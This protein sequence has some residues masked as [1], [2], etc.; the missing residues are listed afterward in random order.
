MDNNRKHVRISY[1]KD[2]ELYAEEETLVGK[3]LD[4][5]NSGIRVVVPAATSGIPI[6]RISITLPSPH[7]MV[8][9]PCRVIRSDTKGLEEGQHVLGIEFSYQSESQMLL[10]DN[11]IREMRDHQLAD[12][13]DLSEMRIL[14]RASCFITSVA[15]ATPGVSIISIENISTEGCLVSFEGKLATHETLQMEFSLPGDSRRIQ[16]AATVAYVINNDFRVYNRAGIIFAALADL[17]F[18]KI[19]N[20]I[21]RSVSNISIRRIQERRNE[22]HISNEYLVSTREQIEALFAQLKKEQGKI[23][24]LFENSIMMFEIRMKKI[25]RSD[26]VFLTSMP[27]EA[28]G[29]NLKKDQAAYFSF[30]LHGSS[31]YF[32]SLLRRTGR[33]RL[34]FD[35][36]DLVYQSEKRSHERKYIGDDI[37]ISL[38]LDNSP[39]GRIN[40]KLINI[41]RRGFLCNVVLHPAEREFIKSG[42]AVFY[43]FEKEVG[44]KS[45]GE[46]RHLKEESAEGGLVVQ[47]GIEAGI[48]RSEFSFRRFTRSGWNRKATKQRERLSADP[49]R[50]FPDVVRYE[51]RNGK[52][53]TGLLNYTRLDAEAPVIILPPAFGKK[54]ESLSPLVATILENFTA[55]EKDVITIRYDGINRPGESYHDDMFPK[56]G[57]EMLHYRISQGLED[58]EATLDFVCTNDLFKPSSVIV[59]AFSMSALDARKLAARDRRI[60]YL[61]HV[62]GATCARSS[63]RTITGGIDIV[64]NT[65]SGLKSGLAGVLG[66]ILNLDVLSGDL[67]EN[68]YAYMADV[69]HDMSC[70]NI[71]VSWI[72]GRHDKWIS[73]REI[74]DLMSIQAGG[75]RELIEIPTGHNL[76]SSED[77]IKTF[78]IITDLIYRHLHG[79]RI[80]PFDPDRE[81][82]VNLITYERERLDQD[83]NINMREYWK[84]YLVG[85]NRNSIGYDFYGNI[86]AFEEFLSCQA[87]LLELKN[88]ESM[89]DMG[90]GTGLFFERMITDNV[91]RGTNLSGV[92]LVLVDLVPEALARAREKY[93]RLEQA[94]G[95]LLP[96]QIDF[97]QMDLEPNR[98]LPVMR[99]MENRALPVNYL[100]SRVDGLK[101]TTIDALEHCDSDMIGEVMRGACVTGD[102][103]TRLK[104]LIGENDFRAVIDFNRAARYLSGTLTSDDFRRNDL[105]NSRITPYDHDNSRPM[106]DIEFTELNFGDRGKKLQLDFADKSFDKI[107]ASL[108]V[109]YLFNP[110]E[111]IFDF[112]RILIPGGR[113]LVSSMKPDSDI[114]IIFTDYIN[115]VHTFNIKEPHTRNREMNLTAARAMLNEAASLFQLEEDGLF[116]FYSSDELAAMMMKAGF[117]NIVVQFSFGN[118]PQAVIVTGEKP[119]S[120]A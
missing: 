20:Y 81:G 55:H 34:V 24:V 75:S 107:T 80:R 51:N 31:Y 99:F 1:V 27:G 108:L 4:I 117:R 2:I 37:D 114:S 49:N 116:R 42:Q 13:D 41:S 106:S 92:R 66:Q 35:L 86:D 53:I 9:I 6:N 54:K 95:P 78:K 3:S 44:L 118:P 100:R 111:I 120:K 119:G 90:C 33:N 10:V 43:S 113:L 16:A 64:G 45:F 29:L 82:M 26:A 62:M 32:K 84:E 85:E 87:S 103:R 7:P 12:K 59:V 19:H 21:V 48:R 36:P 17:D 18:I 22:N 68:K 96:Q 38:E 52:R 67:I 28:C 14:P 115:K 93:M 11:F 76:R 25:F 65:R 73:E 63:F 102:M 40:G 5:S 61:I 50:L 91:G 98:L 83:R 97:V 110:D 30:F 105:L 39:L 89:A 15:C 57:Y 47:I 104:E 69:R 79:R 60:S 88:G 58:L 109:S 101:N 72:Y 70:I 46:I 23:H 77:A 74:R 71:P 112:Y 8:Q 56:R 94:Y